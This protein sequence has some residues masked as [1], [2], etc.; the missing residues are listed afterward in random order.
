MFNLDK[1]AALITGATGGIG[2]AIVK[3]LHNFGAYIVATGTNKEKLEQLQSEYGGSRISIISADLANASDDLFERAQSLTSLNIE[4]LVANAG[5]CKDTLSIRMKN[6]DWDSVIN[7]NLTSTFKLNRSAIKHMMRHKY[8]RVINL[9]SVVGYT[10]NAGQ[11]NYTAAKAGIVGM[12]KTLAI[13]CASRGITVNCI[14]PGFIETPMTENLSD[15]LKK[16]ILQ[17]VPMGKMGSPYDIASA[18]L[19]LASQEAS[20]I[21]GQTIHINGGMF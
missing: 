7:L 15:E 21:T 3:L 19:F 20:Y 2:R 10:G 4:I 11:A 12:S 17:K 8:G 13:E 1:S 18:V 16:Q 9:S 5:I 6:E 14:A